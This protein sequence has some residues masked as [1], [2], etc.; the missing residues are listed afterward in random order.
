M[1]D[2]AADISAYATDL[3]AIAV[4]AFGLYLLTKGFQWARRVTK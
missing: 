4:A 2:I 1:S 3:T